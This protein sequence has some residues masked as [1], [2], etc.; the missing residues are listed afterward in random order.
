MSQAK[1]LKEVH[2]SEDFL[3]VMKQVRKS[4]LGIKLYWSVVTP[5]SRAIKSLL[6]AGDIE[7][8]EVIV[9][10]NKGENKS[11]EILKLNPAGTVPFMIVKGKVFTES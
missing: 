1:G 11:P 3:K 9:D 6:V 7:H 10:L 8:S 5:S 4:F 2:E